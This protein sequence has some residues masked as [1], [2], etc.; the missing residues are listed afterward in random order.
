[1][2][3]KNANRAIRLKEIINAKARRSQGAEKREER[4]AN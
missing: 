4:I 3:R 1:M 2:E